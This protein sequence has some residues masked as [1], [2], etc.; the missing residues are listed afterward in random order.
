MKILTFVGTMSLL[1]A[2]VGA[3]VAFVFYGEIEIAVGLLVYS[4]VGGLWSEWKHRKELNYVNNL[5]YRAVQ[6]SAKA[7]YVLGNAYYRGDGV[8]QNYAEAAQWY[9]RAAEQKDPLID[10]VRLEHSREQPA[11]PPAPPKVYLNYP[12]HLLHQSSSVR[13]A[14]IALSDMY[15]KGEGVPQDSAE[16]QRWSSA[17]Q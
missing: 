3:L 15:R 4:T 6:G 10:P 5:H 1:P 7:Q 8:P 9:R 12:P 13:L 2:F 17:R 11:S 14:R 16:A